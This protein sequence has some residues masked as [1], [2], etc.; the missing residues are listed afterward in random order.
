MWVIASTSLAE[1]AARPR[2]LYRRSLG[3]GLSRF[4]SPVLWR[5]ASDAV[6]GVLPDWLY[7][8]VVCARQAMTPA[9]QIAH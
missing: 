1:F 3:L 5:W 8:G 2:A 4:P 6:P 7:I 9:L